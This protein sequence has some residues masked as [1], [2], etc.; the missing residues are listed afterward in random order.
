[1]NLSLV[2]I[3]FEDH[4]ERDKIQD[5]HNNED[6]N[7]SMLRMIDLQSIPN[8]QIEQGMQDKLQHCFYAWLK[9][10]KVNENKW[11]TLNNILYFDKDYNLLGKQADTQITNLFLLRKLKI[12][13]TD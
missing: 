9:I 2:I 10:C 13:Y 3:R 1:M 7:V 8:F 11:L 4:Y 6:L 5:F 12:D